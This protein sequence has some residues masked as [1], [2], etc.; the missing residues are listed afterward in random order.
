MLETTVMYDVLCGQG[1]RCTV[2]Q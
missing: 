1:V 2:C